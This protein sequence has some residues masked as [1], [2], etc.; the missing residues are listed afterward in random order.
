MIV[1]MLFT[2]DSA[3]SGRQ[4]AGAHSQVDCH[5][6]ERAVNFLDL[7]CDPLLTLDH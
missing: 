2:P 7:N 3:S 1:W 5:V 6:F 4:T